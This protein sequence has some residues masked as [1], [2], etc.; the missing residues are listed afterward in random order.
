MYMEII[1]QTKPLGGVLKIVGLLGEGEDI[2]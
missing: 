1:I 2:K